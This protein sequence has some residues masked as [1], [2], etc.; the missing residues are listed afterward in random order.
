MKTIKLL[1]AKWATSCE[2]LKEI[3]KA[4]GQEIQKTTQAL[5]VE[6]NGKS[7][8]LLVDA[9]VIWDKTTKGPA[10]KR[11]LHQT[12]ARFYNPLGLF[13]PVSV[14]GKILCQETWCRGLQ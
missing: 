7:D 5:G 11:K 13:L 9:R 6:W 14:F 8:I 12:T 3:W 10:T 2:E 4:E 1:M